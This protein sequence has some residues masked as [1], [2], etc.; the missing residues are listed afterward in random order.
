MSG[1]IPDHSPEPCPGKRMIPCKVR[2]KNIAGQKLGSPGIARLRKLGGGHVHVGR[3]RCAG[4]S[5]PG[6]QPETDGV[7][8]HSAEMVDVLRRGGGVIPGRWNDRV[9]PVGRPAD[10]APLKGPASRPAVGDRGDRV[11]AGQHD[12]ASQRYRRGLREAYRGGCR[13]RTPGRIVPD[14][15]GETV[16]TGGIGRNGYRGN[17]RV[18]TADHRVG[19]SSR[20]GYRFTGV[21]GV[22]PGQGERGA[23]VAEN[24]AP[25]GRSARHAAQG[26]GHGD[27]DEIGPAG[28]GSR[29]IPP[30]G[31]GSF[32]QVGKRGIIGIGIGKRW[33]V[34]SADDRPASC[35]A[36]QPASAVTTSQRGRSGGR[37]TAAEHLV[38]SG[39]HRRHPAVIGDHHIIVRPARVA[40][41]DRPAKHGRAAGSRAQVQSGRR[42]RKVYDRHAVVGPDDRPLPGFARSR[43][44]GGHGD[45]PVPGAARPVGSR[46]GRGQIKNMHVHRVAYQRSVLALGPQVK[47]IVTAR[48]DPGHRRVHIVLISDDH[49][50]TALLRPVDVAQPG[51]Q[52]CRSAMQP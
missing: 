38:G 3:Y 32:N 37:I 6:S 27:G 51:V 11:G 26:V 28:A 1:R 25:A 10:D 7:G 34:R 35:L 2:L 31:V 36:V 9:V 12:V 23:T 46:L 8:A 48:G 33:H 50:R 16:R 42:R 39:I 15:V 45:H 40:P 5:C 43:R 13:R 4:G 47:R 29:H 17:R 52:P 30:Q 18:R 21:Q 22:V 24:L 41:G 44:I 19:S 20:P 49:R 14:R